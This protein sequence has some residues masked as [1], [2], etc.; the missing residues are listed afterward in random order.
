[1]GAASSRE[2]IKTAGES[3]AA[4]CRSHNNQM[5]GRAEDFFLFGLTVYNLM[6]L[7]ARGYNPRGAYESK[8]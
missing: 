7:K 4:G 6:E 1:M 3:I 5:Q 2:R 8:R